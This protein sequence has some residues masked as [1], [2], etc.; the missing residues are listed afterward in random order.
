MV[1]G[2]GKKPAGGFFKTEI[3]I[4]IDKKSLREFYDRYIFVQKYLKFKLL[5][6]E[7]AETKKGY[8][9]RLIVDLPYEYSDKDIVLL[10]LL[11]G[12]DWK[13][14]TIN[15]FRVIHN[16]DDWNV[17]FRKKY[18]IFKAGNLFKL[19]SKEKCIGCLHGDVS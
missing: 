17:L 18:R 14:A 6:Y 12:D 8:H 10:Q 4:D 11:L 13:R 5:G 9:V 1:A 2:S 16:L 15:Y 7:I 19:A 3:L